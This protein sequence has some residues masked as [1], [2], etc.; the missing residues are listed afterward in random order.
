[1]AAHKRS[2]SENLIGADAVKRI[3]RE[4]VDVNGDQERG[5]GTMTEVTGDTV[6]GKATSAAISEHNSVNVSG[7]ESHEVRE[8]THLLRTPLTELA[9]GDAEDALAQPAASKAL[10]TTEILELVISHL[11]GPDL[12]CCYQCERFLLQAQIVRRYGALE[13][14]SRGTVIIETLAL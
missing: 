11:C 9:Q 14:S 1:M 8:T 4:S 3:R 2:T 7:N 12:I 10:Y 13:L 6:L 5:I